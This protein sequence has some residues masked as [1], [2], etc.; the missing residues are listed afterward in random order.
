MG[1]WERLPKLTHVLGFK[2]KSGG[3]KSL[4]NGDEREREREVL[5]GESL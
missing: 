3:Y 1:I 5:G 4:S 2:C